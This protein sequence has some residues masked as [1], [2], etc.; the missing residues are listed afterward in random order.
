MPWEDIC[1]RGGHAED[2][3]VLLK[4]CG[5][6]ETL[7]RIQTAEV[8]SGLVD[9]D[10]DTFGP[11]LRQQR[12][13]RGLTLK[14]IADST[15]IRES[16]LAAL[17]RND[18]SQWPEGIFR[19]AFLRE[20]AAAIGLPPEPLVA[21]FSRLFAEDRLYPSYSRASHAEAPEN[22]LRLTLALDG[23][24]QSLQKIRIL[25]GADAIIMHHANMVLRLC[26]SFVGQCYHRIE[27]VRFSCIGRH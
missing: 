19:R 6:C 4:T 22:S 15:K 11:H 1:L 10:R 17:E 18:V 8:M 9:S 25:L 23:K 24:W 12:E 5:I 16:L 13:S 20:Y 3:K 2:A 14:A 21:E 26:I 7:G 27:G